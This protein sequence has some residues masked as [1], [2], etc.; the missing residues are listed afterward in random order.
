[1]KKRRL[2]W[3]L[4]V[5]I[6]IG[7]LSFLLAGA[8]EKWI[9]LP[10]AK[11]FWLVKGYYGAIPQ[12]VTWIAALSIASL[13][14]LLTIR[15]PEFDPG[16]SRRKRHRLQGAIHEMAFWIRRSR[17]GAYPR[18]HVAHLLAEL[19]L[20]I[21]EKKGTRADLDHVLEIL[22]RPPSPEILNYLQAGLSTNPGE[23]QRTARMDKDQTTALDQ[24]IEPVLDYLDSL[25]EGVDD[26]SA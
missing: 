6:F 18:W 10:A 7:S 26:H 11:V 25:M 17:K 13:M 1:M 14:I 5:F 22:E 20:S 15:H 9:I 19:T 24:E 21:L 12:A 8:A 16:W 23:F 4:L 3:I 2:A